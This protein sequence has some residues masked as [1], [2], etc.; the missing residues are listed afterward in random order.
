MERV[1]QNNQTF[2]KDIVCIDLMSDFGFK[3]VFLNQRFIKHFLDAMLNKDVKDIRY[4]PTE[5]IGETPWEKKSFFDI[6]CRIDDEDYIIEM[7]LEGDDNFKDRMR[8]YESKHIVSQVHSGESYTLPKIYVIAFVNFNFKPKLPKGKYLR[9]V[10]E[11]DVLNRQIFDDKVVRYFIEMPNFALGEEDC[12]DVFSKWI[13]SIKNAKMCKED[14]LPFTDDMV[15]KD[16]WSDVRFL[17]LTREEQFAYLHEQWARQDEIWQR[18]TERINW[19]KKGREEGIAEGKIEAAKNMKAD[20]MSNELI[21]KYTGLSLD[22]VES[23]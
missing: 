11:C 5:H 8:V 19:T 2:M 15:F 22:I 1:T 13:Y 23:L 14:K 6:C 20:G 12:V 4:L 10:L 16:L 7:Q 9:E 18:N 17:N 21:C 3:K